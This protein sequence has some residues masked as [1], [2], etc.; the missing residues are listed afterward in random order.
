MAIRPAGTSNSGAA[1]PGNVHPPKATPKRPGRVVGRVG[2]AL[3]RVEIGAGLRCG[4]GD[5][6]DDEAAGDAA[7]RR[8][9]LVGRAGDVVGDQEQAARR[10]PRS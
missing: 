10:C 7:A 1:S 9:L 4:S 2:D 5:L 8:A 3:H 6:E